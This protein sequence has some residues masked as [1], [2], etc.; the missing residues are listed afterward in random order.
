M[1]LPA[2]LEGLDENVTASDREPDQS[3]GQD[4]D[5]LAG[6]PGLEPVHAQLVGWIA[7]IRAE[8]ARREAGIAVGRPVWKNLVFTG[9]PGTGKSRAARAVARIYQK[10]GL[11]G[12]GHVTEMAAADLTGTKLTETAILMREAF[13]R[14]AAGGMLM[15]NGAHAWSALPDGGQQAL[16][17]LY[18]E[19]TRSRDGDRDALAVILAGQAGPLRSLMHASPPLAARFPAVIDFPSYTT[20]QLAAILATLA[21]EAGFTL[22]PVAAARAA[23]VLADAEGH[24]GPGNARLAVRLLDQ[25]TASQAR[26]IMTAAFPPRD[27]AALSTIQAEDIPAHIY[28]HDQSA[29]DERPGQYL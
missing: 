22:A 1:Q 18:Q 20:R 8:L 25:A 2:G 21:R 17:C 24:H 26:R 4:M 13:N 29:D 6:L 9:G 10:L 12:L 23:T 15:I 14:A 11:M 3:C 16:R 7:V 28:L 27:I 5:E 19:L